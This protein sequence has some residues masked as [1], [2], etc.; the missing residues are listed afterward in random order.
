MQ[1]KDQ[2]TIP[3]VP[4]VPSSHNAF[5]AS[6]LRR[7]A[8][9]DEPPTAG[10]ADTAGP[11][12]IVEIPGEGFGL[13]R[14]GESLQRGYLPA[15]VFADR[16][17]AVVAAAVLPGTGRE[18]MLRL[19]NQPDEDGFYAV[20]LEDG[21]VV[22][23]FHLYDQPLLD[24]MNGALQVIRLPGSLAYLNEAAGPVTLVRCGAILDER[25]PA[26]EATASE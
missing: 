14:E 19:S 20:T 7:F 10:E 4:D 9:V 1:G 13:F 12:R 6:F 21:T 22:G 17:L 3:S 26:A 25:L 8:E 5:A 16:S 15:A 24:A 23:R 11:W 2:N 18:P